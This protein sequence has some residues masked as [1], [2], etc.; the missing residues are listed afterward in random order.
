[1]T[2]K[3]KPE[4]ALDDNEQSQRFIETAH[5]LEVDE[6]GKAFERA[7]KG[8]KKNQPLGQIATNSFKNSVESKK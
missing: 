3:P 5:E 2:K 1:M 6:S 8:I 4:P 7:I